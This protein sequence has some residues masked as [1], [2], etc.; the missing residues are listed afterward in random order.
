MTPVVV[1][2]ARGSIAEWLDEH[3][4]MSVADAV[5]Q[6]IELWPVVLQPLSYRE[7]GYGLT[8]KKLELLIRERRAKRTRKLRVAE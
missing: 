3:E 5:D 4:H 7:P 1:S 6:V 2:P 8:R